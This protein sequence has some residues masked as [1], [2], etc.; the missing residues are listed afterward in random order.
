ML[1]RLLRSAALMTAAL[2]GLAGCMN[3]RIQ[4]S[5]EL[6]TQIASGESVVILAKPQIE[7]AAA[8]AEFMDCVGKGLGSGGQG[9]AVL[10]EAV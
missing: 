1:P 8:D 10:L 9:I 2:L 3:A 4:E 5:R 7:G 6:P